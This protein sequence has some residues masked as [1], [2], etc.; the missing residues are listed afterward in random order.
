VTL[1]VAFLE[2]VV[3]LDFYYNLRYF[4][5]N[6]MTYY[7]G[8]KKR[9]GQEI[10]QIIYQVVTDIE[11][12]AGI[13]Y[14]GYCEPFC[15]MLGVYQHIP[16]L[17]KD[18]KP[19]LKYLAGDRNDELVLM[20]KAV[21]KGWKPPTKCSKTE[22]EKLKKS[23]KKSPKKSF[24][25]HA[26]SIRGVYMGCYFD[27][28]NIP[29]QQKSVV[30]IGKKVKA[31][32]FKGGDYTQFTNLKDFVIY[33][34]P[35]YLDTLH[36]YKTEGKYDT[37]FDSKKFYEWCKKMSEHNLVFVSEFKMPKEFKKIWTK[38]KEGLFLIY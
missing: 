3:E 30:E 36:I 6:K 27:R 29:H 25:G 32:N 11:K 33:C 4:H 8:G 9:I 2:L 38:G 7:Q 18:H 12:E 14:K 21:Q 34:D 26:A 31:L 16:E 35:P 19:P 10:A 5:Y 24:I 20:W 13:K 23:P 28:N 15:G 1:E 17:F 22:F 37:F